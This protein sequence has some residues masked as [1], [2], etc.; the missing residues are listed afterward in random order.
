[1]P[2]S[3]PG[4]DDLAEWLNSMQER[5]RRLLDPDN[6]V[7][8]KRKFEELTK[9]S[10]QFLSLASRFLSLATIAGNAAESMLPPPQKGKASRSK[11]NRPK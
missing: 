6:P 2:Q 7:P 11:R 1:M 4:K 9:M 10:Q 3:Q 5:V 8:S